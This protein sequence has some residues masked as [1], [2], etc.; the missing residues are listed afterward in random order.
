MTIIELSAGDTAWVLT[1]ASLVFLM[2]PGLAMFYGGMTRAFSALNMM[3]MSFAAMGVVAVLWILYGFGLSFGPDVGGLFGDPRGFLGLSALFEQPEALYGDNIPVF[4]FVAFQA[5]FAIITVALVSGALADRM[6]FGAWLVFTGLWATLVYFP[7]AHMVFSFD[8]YV[9]GKGGWIA[10][11]ITIGAVT[12]AI[13]FAGGTAI[14]INAGAAGLVA[15]LIL[16][17]RIG[18][19]SRPMRPHNMTLV[20]LG[21]GL[22]W[23]GWFGFNAGSALAADGTASYVWVNTLGATGAAMI[24]WMLTEKLRDGRFTSLGAASGAVAGLVAI[25][26]SCVAVSPVGAIAI[27]L[28]AGVVCAM[29]VTWKFK[30]GYDDSLDVVG[31]HLVG[32]L[33]GT[34]LIGLFSVDDGLLYGHGPARLAVQAVGAFSLMAYSAVVTAVIVLSIKQVMGLRLSS[35]DELAGIDLAEHAEAAYDLSNVRYASYPGLSHT[36]VVPA[37]E[38]FSPSATTTTDLGGQS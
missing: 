20:M 17:R 31:V 18:F 36:V 24:G 22:L 38:D 15:A 1:A 16:G 2:T 9:S 30:L 8:G 14:H 19:G 27:G 5:A 37:R 25:T 6:K 28:A 12:G 3:M 4:A 35:A 33:V 23:F 13:D 32:G 34:L 7:A 26:P 10:N 29:A 21:A 11:D